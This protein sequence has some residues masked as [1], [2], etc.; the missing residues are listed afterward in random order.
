MMSQVANLYQ[1]YQKWVFQ[2]KKNFLRT[3]QSK[4][5][6]LSLLFI[7]LFSSCSKQNSSKDV[8]VTYF[9]NKPIWKEWLL[10]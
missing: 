4:P 6:N 1:Y 2:E 8:S 7:Y 10:H 9:E 3:L 5:M